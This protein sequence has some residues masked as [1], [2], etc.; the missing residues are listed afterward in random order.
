MKENIQKDVQQIMIYFCQKTP[1]KKMYR[2]LLLWT[3]AIQHGTKNIK[4][5]KTTDDFKN[6]LKEWIWENIH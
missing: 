2:F 5:A 1:E 3:K 6:K 4:D